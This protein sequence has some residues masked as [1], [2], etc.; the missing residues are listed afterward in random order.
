MDKEFNLIGAI[1]IILKWKMHILALIVV[2]AI[3][4]AI[5]SVFI[6]DEWYL[7]YSTFYPTNQALTDRASI[8]GSETKAEYFGDKADVNRV[9]TIANSVPIIDFVI[10]SFKLAEHYDVSKEKS[11]WRTIVRKKFEKKYEAIKT[12]RDAVQISLYDT[13]P[14]LAAAIVNTIVQKVDVLNK[15]HVSYSKN[16]MYDAVNY[17]VQKLKVDAAWYNDT[18]AGLGQ[19]YNIKVTTGADGTV[20]V[21]GN[22]YHA[23]QIYKTLMSRQNNTNRELNN[24]MNIT[25]QLEVSRQNNETS[26]YILE[27]GF[28]SDR[29]EKPVRS[30]VVLITVLITAFVS[31]VGVLLIEQIK[32]IKAQL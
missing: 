1:R 9:L 24:L 3:S 12:E 25:G 16:K 5:F 26:L 14:K 28:P 21:E 27:K 15:E 11:Y 30:L 19:R 13:D 22:D 2:S 23:V 29:R 4:A 32:E 6:M 17:Q 7:S 31:V 8:F 10:D 18:L 20:L